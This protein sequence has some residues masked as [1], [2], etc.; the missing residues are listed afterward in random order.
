MSTDTQLNQVISQT[1]DTV[2][3]I[4]PKCFRGSVVF[5]A[6]NRETTVA[7]ATCSTADKAAEPS[8]SGN[9]W[10]KPEVCRML[11]YCMII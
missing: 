7:A 11:Y 3:D 4:F 1:A 8:F 10:K 9:S 6:E 5:Q 2:W